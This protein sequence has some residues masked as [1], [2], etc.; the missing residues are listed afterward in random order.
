MKFGT[1]LWITWI[2]QP[3]CSEC[4]SA[5]LAGPLALHTGLSNSLSGIQSMVRVNLRKKERNVGENILGLANGISWQ[6]AAVLKMFSNLVLLLMR[7]NF[8]DQLMYNNKLMWIVVCIRVDC[9]IAISL[10]L[11]NRGD[12]DRTGECSHRRYRG[13]L[14]TPL[15]SV[16][17]CS[18][19][20]LQNSGYERKQN[21]IHSH[22]LCFLSSAL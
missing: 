17:M 13:W 16:L 22:V 18:F 2:C 11:G 5:C 15:L 3:C 14:C 19:A 1:L 8:C 12:V 21:L 10:F 20:G 4:V 6:K 7:L 9:G